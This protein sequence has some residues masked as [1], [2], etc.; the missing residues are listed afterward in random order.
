VTDFGG[1][2]QRGLIFV[3]AGRHG[4]GWKPF[5]AELQVVLQF[6]QSRHGGRSAGCHSNSPL[7]P[8]AGQMK[9]TQRP[10]LELGGN[11]SYVEAVMGLRKF[12][13]FP[14]SLKGSSGNF[15]VQAPMG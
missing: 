13:A 12:P 3:L 15:E 11:S 4:R 9:M 1:G 6:F 14:S 8:D 7:A 5:A 2:R 10:P